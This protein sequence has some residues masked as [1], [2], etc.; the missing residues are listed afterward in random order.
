VTPGRLQLNPFLYGR[1]VPPKRFV[2]RQEAL[3]TIFS[4][5]H[6]GQSSAVTG[7]PH[8]GKSSFLQYIRDETV[9]REWLGPA[10]DP[11]AF[12]DVDCHLL[13]ASYGPNEFWSYLLDHIE[14]SFAEHAVRTQVAQARSSGYL[15]FALR[16]LFELL[17]RAGKRLIV[18]IDEFDVLMHHARFNTPDFFGAL[19]GLS[20]ASDSLALVAASRM[21]TAEMNRRSHDINPLG[22]P[23]FNNLTEVHLRPLK[24]AEVDELIA[25]MLDGT[26]VQFPP[27][28]RTYIVRQ[29]GCHP[30]LVQLAAAT[31]FEA[32]ARG[33]VGP[34]RYAEVSR[35]LNRL[36]AAH[37]EDM[38]RHLGPALHQPL[39]LLAR[40][41]L[42]NVPGSLEGF[43]VELEKL[44]AARLIERVTVPSNIP[45]LVWRG[46]RWRVAA[47]IFARWVAEHVEEAGAPEA[48]IEPATLRKAIAAAFSLDEMRTICHD[49]GFNPENLAGDTHDAFARELV[50][51]CEQRMMLGRLVAVCRKMRPGMRW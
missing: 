30:F 36:G 27:S 1:P 38:W 18:V 29:T 21:S 3:Q 12:V 49:L 8:I 16:Q 35:E 33:I 42:L 7:A 40:A 32:S 51:A 46:E 14:Q 34:P 2:G 45:L 41:E 11:F 37:F 20:V 47:K 39:R 17:S 10:G 23:F 6:T 28:D 24:L 26:S 50:I 43:G 48:K 4:R 25:R 44:E 9:R 19:R 15:S 31:L 5:I 22:S 13:P